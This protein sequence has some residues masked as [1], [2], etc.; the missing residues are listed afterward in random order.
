MRNFK[1][2]N[3]ISHIGALSQP[4]HFSSRSVKWIGCKF[5]MA[6]RGCKYPADVF[7]YVYS[8]FIK[9]RAKKYSVKASAKM[10]EAYKAYFGMPV[11]DQDKAW[12]PHFTCEQCKKTLEGWYK[13]ERRAMK[14]AIPRVWREPSDPLNNCYF[15][16]VDPSKCRTGKNAPAV[17]YPGIPS[18]IA[19]VPH[20]PELPVSF[21]SGE[22]QLSSQ[23]HSMSESEE[24]IGDP[25]YSMEVE[26]RNPYYPN[27]KDILDLIRDL[28]LIKSNAEL[29]ISRLKQ[30]NLLDGSI[31]G[32]CIWK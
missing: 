26:E 14:F 17:I 24:D 23:E 8:Q 12:A 10:Y 27:Q 20:S 21:P 32:S 25:D 16:M 5:V 28:G 13:R 19:P 31:F 18:S 2:I 30:W 11:I 1:N 9:T 29:L 6:T 7:C 22:K 4:F 3:S 15:C